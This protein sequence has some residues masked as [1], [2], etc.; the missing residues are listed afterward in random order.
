[1]A[2]LKDIVD[3]CLAVAT[4]YTAINSQTYNEVN[5]VN[6]EDND[7]D[8]SLCFCLTKGILV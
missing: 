8:F 4:A 2:R 1:M 7:K 3:E 5:A 6:Y